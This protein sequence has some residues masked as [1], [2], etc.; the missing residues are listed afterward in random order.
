MTSWKVDARIPVRIVS[1]LPA[2]GTAALLAEE[3]LPEGVGPER[4]CAVFRADELLAHPG[5]CTCCNGQGAAAGALAALFRGRATGGPWFTEVVALIRSP[6]GRAELEDALARDMLT[7][8][9]FRK[10]GNTC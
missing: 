6:E 9:R 2:L 5:G 3:A 10:L 8:A 4:S 1:A 7:V